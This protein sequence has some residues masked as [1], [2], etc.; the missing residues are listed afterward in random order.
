M[1]ILGLKEC[2][3]ECATVCVKSEVMLHSASASNANW[4]QKFPGQNSRVKVPL[5]KDLLRQMASTRIVSMFLSVEITVDRIS[6]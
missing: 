4:Q 2:L 5:V 1:L 3:V 6:T